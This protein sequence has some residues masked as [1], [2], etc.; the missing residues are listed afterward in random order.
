MLQNRLETYPRS[1]SSSATPL[2]LNAAAILHKSQVDHFHDAGNAQEPMGS[3]PINHRSRFAR[4]FSRRNPLS[5][6]LIP[7]SRFIAITRHQHHRINPPGTTL[8]HTH[9]HTR[10]T[11][12]TGI[13]KR[14]V[15]Q[16]QRKG[17]GTM[18]GTNA[19]PCSTLGCRDAKSVADGWPR[20][21]TRWP[22]L[23]HTFSSPPLPSIRCRLLMTRRT[24]PWRARLS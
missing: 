20:C 10:E 19:L 12:K 14:K 24:R 11:G 5:S 2:Y 3:S 4:I 18:R 21:C 23:S 6:R 7:V 13:R 22:G 8:K 15:T 1:A 17:M 16:T 9:T